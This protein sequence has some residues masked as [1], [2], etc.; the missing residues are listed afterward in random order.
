[1]VK[2][3][4]CLEE[5]KTSVQLWLTGYFME[6]KRFA[7]MMSWKRSVSLWISYICVN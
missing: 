6:N 3:M 4:V 7:L 5:E 1:M 2:S